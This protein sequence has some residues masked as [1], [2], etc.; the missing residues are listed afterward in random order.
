MS[1]E[2][3][4]RQALISF[5]K[6]IIL[7]LLGYIATM[8]FAHVLGPGVLGSYYLFLAY[9]GVFSLIGDGGFGGA[10]TKRISEG[11]EPNQF[12]SAYI[13]LR[14]ILLAVSVISLLAISS[15]LTDFVTSGLLP[16]LILAL[17]TGTIAGFSSTGVY[18]A[19][20]V[21]V[22]QT[23]DF[24]NNSV[25]TIVQIIATY[26]G[27]AAYGL[28]GGFIIGMFV[29]LVI[30]FRYLPLKLARFGKDHLKSLFSFSFWIFLTSSGFLV[31]STADTILIGH[32]LT[33]ADVGIY[34]IA[35]QL[36]GV[37][38]FTCMA[39]N[40]VLFPRMSRWGVEGDLAG[41]KNA[42]SRAFS[43]SLLFALPVLIGGLVLS[44]RLL[45]FL[46]GADFE[47]GSLALIILLIM[48]IFG[49]FVTLQITCLNALD[50]PR[51]SFVATSCAAIIN[52][53]LNLFFIPLLGI[54]GAALAT[55]ISVSL[56]AL[57]SYLYL[58]QTIPILVER[59]PLRNILFSALCMGVCVGVYRLVFD[60]TSVV[61]LAGVILIGAALY[62]LILLRLDSHLKQELVGF[63]QIFGLQ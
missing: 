56:N 23:S 4:R 24:L 34:R 10:A 46:Y 6:L 31:F 60:L 47:Q 27:Y 40:V 14:V 28:A 44:D 38:L 45:F 63:L 21:G 9:Y 52:I 5:A 16:L 8:Y 19:G 7:T 15:Q 57:L 54:T 55:L 49:I 36:S 58:S 26:L 30:N 59:G 17:I 18:G 37:A 48:Q 41:I 42:L 1:I 33:N 11:H 61:S 50:Y 3:I 20:K 32:F 29:G 43:F 62:F 22:V 53:I 51:K 2:P 25:K 35:Y 12:F 13:V 39:L